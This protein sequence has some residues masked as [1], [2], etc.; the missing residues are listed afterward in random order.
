MTYTAWRAWKV[1]GDKVAWTT[2]MYLV[3]LGVDV[4]CG[5][6]DWGAGGRVPERV[7]VHKL[8]VDVINELAA[9]QLSPKLELLIGM[10]KK[11][12]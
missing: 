10:A 11:T 12:K 2:S 1:P 5:V 4:G 9:V 7:D 6:V 3:A 8:F